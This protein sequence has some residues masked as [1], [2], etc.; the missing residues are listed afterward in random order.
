[1]VLSRECW[2]RSQHRYMNEDESGLPVDETGKEFLVFRQEFM[3]IADNVTVFK[4]IKQYLAFPAVILG[5]VTPPAHLKLPG[6]VISPNVKHQQVI[7]KFY[8]ED[9]QDFKIKIIVSKAGGN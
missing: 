3:Y 9:S 1:M 4:N 5:A 8:L 7:T 6:T 2:Q